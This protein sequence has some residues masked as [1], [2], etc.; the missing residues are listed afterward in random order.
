MAEFWPNGFGASTGSPLATATNLHAY[1]NTGKLVYCSSARGADDVW[2]RGYNY[3]YPVATLAQ[4]CANCD[5]GVVVLCDDHDETV[6]TAVTPDA[7]TVI[8]GMGSSNGIPSA[9]LRLDGSA[10]VPIFDINNSEVLIS[11]VYFPELE[12]VSSG[13][14]RIVVDAADFKMDGC[15]FK[16][17]DY[18]ATTPC[19]EL[20]AS[21][22]VAG[23][24]LKN[25]TF[26][27]T[28][29]AKTST[30]SPAVVCDSVSLTQVSWDGVTLD[31]GSFGFGSGNVSIPVGAYL[32]SNGSWTFR[33]LNL[34]LLR[35]ADL[36]VSGALGFAQVATHTGSSKVTWL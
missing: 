34:S 26:L 19:I 18:E 14:G 29:T 1:F 33:C 17:G 23:F 2:P 36:H 25:T 12:E 8:V 32:S 28:A 20:C 30:P 35:G 3:E 24:D 5:G 9:K 11:N 10:N 16:M 6:A 21:A 31:G 4:A 27:S 15:Y 13:A 22:G 7:K